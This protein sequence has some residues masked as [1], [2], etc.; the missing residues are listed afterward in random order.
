MS[1]VYLGIKVPQTLLRLA[2]PR[3]RHSVLDNNEYKKQQALI[4]YKKPGINAAHHPNDRLYEAYPEEVVQLVTA[5]ST[6]GY[7]QPAMRSRHAA[8]PATNFTDIHRKAS[9]N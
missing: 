2:I 4:D 5:D 7:T 3:R 1:D 8:E 6:H 9:P